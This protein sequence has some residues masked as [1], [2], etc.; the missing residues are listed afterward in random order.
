MKNPKF[1]LN[2]AGATMLELMVTMLIMAILAALVAPSYRSYIAN[3]QALT[4]ADALNASLRLAKTEALQRGSPVK[5]CGADITAQTCD[6]TASY[7]TYGW[8]VIDV[9]SGNVLHNYTPNGTQALYIIEGTSLVYSPSGLPSPGAFTFV[10]TP[11][12]C[13]TGYIISYDSLNPGGALQTTSIP[14]P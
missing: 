3:N 7:W 14:C 8:Q 4:V 6:D 10:V 1:V 9:A 11:N 2:S 5:V 12:H 13:A